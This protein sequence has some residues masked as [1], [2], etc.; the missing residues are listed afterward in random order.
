MMRFSFNRA[1]RKRENDKK[2][3]FPDFTA[4]DIPPW[5]LDPF[6]TTDILMDL[7]IEMRFI[8]LMND[9]ELKPSYMRHASQEYWLQTIITERFTA[10]WKKKQIFFYCI[11]QLV[12]S[13]RHKCCCCC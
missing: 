5:I 12:F 4:L 13:K 7:S 8:D 1:S 11:S 9:F 6:N 10:L 2:M 3:Q